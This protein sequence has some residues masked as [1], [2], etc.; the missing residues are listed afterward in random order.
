MCSFFVCDETPKK[1]TIFV[2]VFWGQTHRL[3][4]DKIV[5]DDHN[6]HAH[7]RRWCARVYIYIYIKTA[8]FVFSAREE[9]ERDREIND[10]CCSRDEYE[11]VL[12]EEANDDDDDE[13]KTFFYQYDDDDDDDDDDGETTFKP[14]KQ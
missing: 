7:A 4:R 2:E 6:K 3:K 11:R 12:E 10:F 8:F 13:K 5:L 1:T 14:T 9:R